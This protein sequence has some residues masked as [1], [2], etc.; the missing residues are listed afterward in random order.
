MAHC[1]QINNLTRDCF[2][3]LKVIAESYSGKKNLDPQDNG[4]QTLL[5]GIAFYGKMENERN[6]DAPGR[7]H[8][9]CFAT[10][11]AAVKIYFAL[12]DLMDR[13]ETGRCV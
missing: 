10:P 3:R 5:R 11:R 8:A 2:E 13:I 6:N 1:I 9:S 4:V 12:L 7:F